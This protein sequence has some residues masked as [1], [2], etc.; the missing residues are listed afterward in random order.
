MMHVY[1]ALVSPRIYKMEMSHEQAVS[2][3]SE[4]YGK[5]FDPGMVDAFIEIQEEFRAIARRFY[6]SD[7][8][9]EEKKEQLDRFLGEAP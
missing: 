6:D 8:V 3:V 1:D 9:M 7:H 4:G 2:I 5:H